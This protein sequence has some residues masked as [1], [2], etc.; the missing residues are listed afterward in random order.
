MIRCKAVAI[1]LPSKIHFYCIDDVECLV[2]RLLHKLTT[3]AAFNWVAYNAIFWRARQ[4][5]FVLGELQVR[6]VLRR[7]S[8]GCGAGPSA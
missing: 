7:L 2:G 6:I 5:L 4:L 1:F 3:F 8:C